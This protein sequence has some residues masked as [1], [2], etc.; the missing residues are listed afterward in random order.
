VALQ[1]R[2]SLA[3]AWGAFSGS[4]VVRGELSVAPGRTAGGGGGC[5][6]WW[7]APKVFMRVLAGRPV[8]VVPRPDRSLARPR[9][10]AFHRAA[11][12]A[13][14]CLAALWHFGWHRH[15]SALPIRPGS[16]PVTAAQTS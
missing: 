11:R 6:E 3:R 1:M 8:A 2:L 15:S 4:R 14:L 12:G 16:E 5:S 10:R 9:R 7:A 13:L